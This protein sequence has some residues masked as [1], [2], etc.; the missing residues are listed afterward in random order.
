MKCGIIEFEQGNISY[1]FTRG[2][3]VV[4]FPCQERAA[5]LLVGCVDSQCPIIA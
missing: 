3:N 5:M 2:D 4:D 1:C